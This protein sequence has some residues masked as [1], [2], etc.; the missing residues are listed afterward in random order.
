MYAR[1]ALSDEWLAAV[2]LRLSR[3]SEFSSTSLHL[4]GFSARLVVGADTDGERQPHDDG[5]SAV[6]DEDPHGSSSST[7]VSLLVSRSLQVGLQA[8]RREGRDGWTLT[9]RSVCFASCLKSR[10]DAGSQNGSPRTFRLQERVVRRARPRG[11]RICL[12]PP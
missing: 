12:I 2:R 9:V 8:S 11:A 1:R 7:S 6:T 4:Q 5:G 3:L 10:E